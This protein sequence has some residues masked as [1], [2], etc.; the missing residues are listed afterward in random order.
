[1]KR[2]GLLGGLL[3]IMFVMQL[4]LALRHS[5]WADEVF[6]LAMATGHSVEHPAAKAQVEFGDFVESE[7]PVSAS[8]LR[9]YVE[10]EETSDGLG[11]VVRAVK[12]ADTSP[13]LYYLLLHVWGR[14]W[15]T[16]DVALRMFSI[17]C[18]LAC[19]PLIVAVG[20]EME[21]EKNGWIAA[22]L[23][24][25]APVGVYYSS[26]GRMYS[27]LW[28]CVLLA[29]YAAVKLYRGAAGWRWQALWVGAGVAGMLVHY[30]FVF[31][32]F[33]LGVFLLGRNGSDRRWRLVLRM[34]AVGVLVLPWYLQL[35]ESLSQWRITQSWVEWK[36]P[37]YVRLRVARDVLAQYFS[38]YGHYL[39]GS[40]RLAELGALSV[41]AV[42]AVATFWRFR[43]KIFAGPKLLLWLWFLAAC[44]GPLLID[45]ARGTYI[46]PYL[47]YTS[48]AL[49]AACL[50]GGLVLSNWRESVSWAGVLL[51]GVCWAP[52]VADIYRSRSRSG[53]PMADVAKHLSE[54]GKADD[55]I[56]VHSIP[57]GAIGLARYTLSPGAIATWVGQLGQRRV[58]ESLLTLMDGRGRVL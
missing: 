44:L 38:G 26:E 11:N 43:T 54:H 48:A 12:V 3:A 46:A 14:L 1:M 4:G 31:P 7:H 16:S 52:S 32:F 50:L 57:T 36:P 37:G 40:H 22:V 15:G 23:F 56:L 18:S 21:S 35:P 29:T 5:L 13:P 25:M 28:L 9:R 51:I 19:V 17:I 27:L 6:S 39:W 10:F 53:Q 8:E 34:A 49:P 45:V 42:A 58:P 33:A 55:L 24:A 41:F 30:Y 2:W 47:R 20:R